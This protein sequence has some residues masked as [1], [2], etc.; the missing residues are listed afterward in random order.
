LSLTRKTRTVN[1]TRFYVLATTSDINIPPPPVEAA[2]KR[3]LVRISYKLPAGNGNVA[4]LLAALGLYVTRIDRR[5]S[6]HPVTFHDIYF[7][8]L[9]EERMV[10][11]TDN[12]RIDASWIKQVEKGIQRVVE[13]GAG[14]QL[15]GYW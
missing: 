8:E 2:R 14:A 9:E 15:L 6:L 5:P 3:A 13:N 11:N 12:F 4:Q 7:V 10:E 1:S